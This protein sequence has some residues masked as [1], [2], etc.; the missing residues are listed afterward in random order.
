MQSDH[1]E[2]ETHPLVQASPT[3]KSHNQDP[4]PALPLG[5]NAF[6]SPLSATPARPEPELKRRGKRT[7]IALAT[8]VSC[9]LA[10]GAAMLWPESQ[11]LTALPIE[12]VADEPTSN[13][14]LEQQ[15]T[16]P[17]AASGA[18]APEV[19]ADAVAEAETSAAES[20]QHAA[21]A[22]SGAVAVVPS[23]PAAA[24]EEAAPEPAA[25]KKAT[26]KRRARRRRARHR[27]AQR[28]R[29]ADA[30]RAELPETP[31]RSTVLA[32][33]KRVTPSVRSCLQ[34]SDGV[35]KVSLSFT[36]S[37]GR[38]SRANVTGVQGS[39]AACVK[40]AVRRAKLPPFSKPSLSISFPF[41]AR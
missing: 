26:H 29:N 18:I 30:A 28:K 31:T 1:H 11:E 34:P 24:P 36:G 32:A 3:P 7:L 37:T 4:F 10:A 9:A 16:Q 15:T 13:G 20:S 35:A 33:M 21:T 6:Q 2:E 38:V 41:S 40:K 25:A 14:A 22:L 12:A 27:A 19:E 39:P 17:S 5:V 8:L 23:E